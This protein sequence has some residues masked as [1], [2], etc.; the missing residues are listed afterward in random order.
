MNKSKGVI[1]LCIT[2]MTLLITNSAKA[3]F[4]LSASFNDDLDTNPNTW[5]AGNTNI[6]G[7]SFVVTDAAHFVFTLT[8]VNPLGTGNTRAFGGGD[9]SIGFNGGAT[10]TTGSIDSG[11]VGDATDNES[12]AF[13]LNVANNNNSWHLIT[14]IDL[15]TVTYH[16]FSAAADSMSF[17]GGTLTTDSGNIVSNAAGFRAGTYN[18]FFRVTAEDNAA[19]AVSEFRVA[20]LSF[21]Y[22]IIPEPTSFMLVFLSFGLIALRRNRS[23]NKLN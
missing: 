13:N 17:G 6:D 8:V 23:K 2:A 10:N 14:S 21:T 20:E 19:G 1:L 12:V 9:N 3:S 4:M 5:G 7:S 11:T 16:G 22:T 15:T 18:S